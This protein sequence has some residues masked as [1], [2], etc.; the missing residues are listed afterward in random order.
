MRRKEKQGRSQE[1]W[2]RGRDISGGPWRRTGGTGIHPVELMR[3][4]QTRQGKQSEQRCRDLTIL[5][6]V[7]GTEGGSARLM[8]VRPEGRQVF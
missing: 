5:R 8:E 2:Q 7:S 3:E 4:R 6:P 1:E